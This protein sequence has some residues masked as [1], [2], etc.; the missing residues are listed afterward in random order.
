MIRNLISV[1]LIGVF[2]TFQSCETQKKSLSDQDKNLIIESAKVTVQKVFD[3][4]NNLKFLDGLN[5]YSGDDDAY[6][7]NN[8]T[9]LNLDDLKK[10]YS[11]IGPSVQ[12]LENTIQSWNST[13]LSENT[14]AFTLP[15]LLKI[16]LDGIP[17]YTGQLIWSAIVQKRNEKW[18][19]IQSHESW[20]NCV[21]V[22]SALTASEAQ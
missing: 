10:S 13:I 11:Q 19:I 4:S 9:L 14:V 7:V 18:V 12:R 15:I 8:G 3:A 2:V 22:A 21:E 16:K 17:E 1:F 5:Y 6:Y 20:L